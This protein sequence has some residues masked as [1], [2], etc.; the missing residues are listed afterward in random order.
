MGET[1]AAEEGDDAEADELEKLKAKIQEFQQDVDED[2][3]KLRK[4]QELQQ[5]QYAIGTPGSA[6]GPCLAPAAS[7]A[8]LFLPCAALAPGKV[9]WVVMFLVPTAIN[10]RI[11]RRKGRNRRTFHLCWQ[12]TDPNRRHRPASGPGR[13]P[14]WS[15]RSKANK[16][17]T[18]L[19]RAQVD[20][21]TTEQ[22]LQALF[23]DCGVVR[24]ITILRDKFSGRSKG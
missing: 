6:P 5:Q 1:Q 23:K 8:L 10:R 12:C 21:Q 19:P 24:R 17:F 3:E 18:R 2:A 16:C 9:E 20:F 15:C 14:H 7:G 22:E 4:F 11:Q 13:G